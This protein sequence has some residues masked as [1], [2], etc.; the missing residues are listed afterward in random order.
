MPDDLRLKHD[1]DSRREAARLFEMGYGYGPVASMISLPREAVRKWLYTFRAVGLEGL[2]NMGRTR[3]KYSWE[4]KC[5]A[6]RAVVGGEMTVAEAMAAYGVASRS[7]LNRWCKL[8]REGG[9]DAL[10]PRPKGR[11]RGA[12]GKSAGMT[13]EQELERRVKRLE[14]ENA[15]LKKSIALKA[16]KRSRTARRRSS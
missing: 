10:R 6:A 5:A 4:L 8:Y 13:R 3:A 2:M 11:P 16:E 9:A 12:G 7:P 1:A 14:A 15:Y